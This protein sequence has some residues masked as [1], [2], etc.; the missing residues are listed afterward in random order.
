MPKDLESEGQRVPEINDLPFVLACFCLRSFKFSLEG[1][2][3]SD[4]HS[5][6]KFQVCRLT[7]DQY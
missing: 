1:P 7:P 6:M 2:F 3:V 5:G 4:L